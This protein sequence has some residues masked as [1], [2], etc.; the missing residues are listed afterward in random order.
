[1]LLSPSSKAAQVQSNV[2][3]AAIIIQY[4]TTT[5]KEDVNYAE[6]PDFDKA[7]GKSNI[8]MNCCHVEN[9]IHRDVG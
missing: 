4:T 1:M 8:F 5:K 3:P 9:D 2:I 6:N 7:M